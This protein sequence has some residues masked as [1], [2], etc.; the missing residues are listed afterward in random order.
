MPPRTPRKKTK[1]LFPEV[2]FKVK[3][4]VGY[5]EELVVCGSCAVLGNFD[6]KHGIRLATNPNDYPIWTSSLVC[7]PRPDEN[8]EYKYVIFRGG[9]FHRWEDVPSNRSISSQLDPAQGPFGFNDTLDSFS[10]KKLPQIKYRLRNV[11]NVSGEG[12][13]ATGGVAFDLTDKTISLEDGESGRLGSGVSDN[14]QQMPSRRSSGPYPGGGG[15]YHQRKRSSSLGSVDDVTISTQDGVVVVSYFL[16]VEVQRNAHG[17]WVVDWDYDNLLSLHTTIRVTRVGTVQLPN[18]DLLTKEDKAQLEQALQPFDCVPVWLDEPGLA[19]KFYSGFCKGVL[20]P[21]FHNVVDI[22]GDSAIEFWAP[23]ALD[24]LWSAYTKVNQHFFKKIVECYNERDLIWIHGFHLLLVPSFLSRKLQ[25][26]KVGLFLH[27]P[28]PSSE[29]FR[30]LPFRED[31]LRGMLVA[32]QIGFHVYEYSRHFLTA[33][34]R[35]LGLTYDC[36]GNG[37]TAVQYNGRA[38][39]VTS[40]HAGVDPDIF[41]EVLMEEPVQAEIARMRQHFHGKFVFTGIDKLE[42][43]KGLHLKLSAY[44]KFLSENPD[45]VGQVVLYQVGISTPERRSDF[46]CVATEVQEL[47]NQINAKYADQGHQVIEY[48]VV[49][50]ADLTMPKRIAR[51]AISDALVVT[52]V[53]DGLNRFPLELVLTQ[54]CLQQTENQARRQPGLNILSQFTS[55][56]RVLAGSLHINPWKTETIARAMKK[57]WTM[58]A[59]RRHMKHS[60]DAN[61][62]TKHTTAFWAYQV[63]LDLKA[64]QKKTGRSETSSVGLGFGFRVLDMEAG[65]NT[66]DASEVIRAYKPARHRLIFMDYGGTLHVD[67]DKGNRALHFALAHRKIEARPPSEETLAVLRQLCSD[68]RNTVFVVS[69][70]DKNSLV[71]GLGTVEGLGLAAE[72]GLF[73]KWPKKG[74]ACGVGNQD[75]EEGWETLFPVYDQSWRQITQTIMDI[76]V[77]RTNGTYI[78][79]KGCALIWQFRDADPEFGF[80][81]SKELEDHLK[82]VLKTFAVDILRGGGGAI[83]DAYIEVRPQGLSKGAFLE[84]VLSRL[85]DSNITLEFA[86]ILGDDTSDEVSFTT[87]DAFALSIEPNQNFQYFSCTV[88]KKPSEANSY[89]NDNE[90]V[91]ELLGSLGKVSSSVTK[92]YSYAN[93]AGLHA[94][95]GLGGS[96][97]RLEVLPEESS[98]MTRS[99]STPAFRHNISEDDVKPISMNQYFKQ[100]EEGN[101]E[102]DEGMEGVFF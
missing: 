89:L 31:L 70:K 97:R 99:M 69:G 1:K 22:Y 77:A 100:I 74:V 91:L 23:D 42:R 60:K 4:E 58:P 35:I 73:F 36:D 64:I 25:V 55:C 19:E 9:N 68:P 24:D 43:L 13:R 44:D 75:V 3:A 67:Q 18:L 84:H 66:L 59:E 2:Q 51:L 17:K 15:A 81:Q 34:V 40:I 94:E 47:V 83:S 29:I 65:F 79:Q 90:E 33:C 82:G 32:D 93:L 72:H 30:T 12:T 96:G 50:R 92:Y 49:S 27:T 76:Y 57:A 39:A 28:F 7:L 26:A 86:L 48:E 41:E 71:N 98:S 78:E 54:H 88:G 46:S 53:R 6:P 101:E 52:S 61:W 37:H 45:A 8:I 38:V 16:P 63:L 14:S 85:A 87:I 80:M 20:W 95:N 102:D 62:V 11:S 5:G 10:D 21:V 56:M